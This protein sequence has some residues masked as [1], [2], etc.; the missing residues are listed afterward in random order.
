MSSDKGR[1]WT[2]AKLLT[3]FSE[4]VDEKEV[5]PFLFDNQRPYITNI[6]N[7]LYITWERKMGLENTQ[8][9]IAEIDESG[10]LISEKRVTDNKYSSFSPR[11]FSYNYNIYLLWSDDP[12]NN[13]IR[14]AEKKGSE[15]VMD[16]SNLSYSIP[17]DSRFPSPVQIK[18]FL[19]IFWENRYRNSS[20]LIFLQPDQFVEMPKLYT[21]F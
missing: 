15:W 4:V 11:I 3:D 10:D 20:R 2:R 18:E 17:G 14:I 6:G 7:R 12:G 5:N 16:K 8:V 13:R 19:Y 21:K 9:H 1:T